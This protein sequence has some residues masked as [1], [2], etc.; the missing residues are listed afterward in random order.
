VRPLFLLHGHWRRLVN[1]ALFLLH[2]HWRRVVNYA[3]GR[4]I[5]SLNTESTEL[6]E[7]LVRLAFKSWISS[8]QDSSAVYNS[9]SKTK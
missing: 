5:A 3:M 2:G 9:L 8:I 4:W 6:E 1:Y 7:Q